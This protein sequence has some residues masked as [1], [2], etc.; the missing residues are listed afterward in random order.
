M[1]LV[2]VIAPRVMGVG[3]CGAVCSKCSARAIGALRHDEQ[4]VRRAFNVVPAQRLTGQERKAAA[5]C[6]NELRY[7]DGLLDRR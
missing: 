3:I 6:N 1:L 7:E 2:L 5:C 4:R